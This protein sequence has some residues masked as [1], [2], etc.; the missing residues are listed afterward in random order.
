M[1]RFRVLPVGQAQHQRHHGHAPDPRAR[2]HD[3]RGG[4]PLGVA[5]QEHDADV[6]VDEVGDPAGQEGQGHR[7]HAA[8]V[9]QVQPVL[10]VRG[11]ISTLH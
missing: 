4:A 6:H 1:C 9:P 11:R 7:H 8:G 10:L 3:V 2:Q 5:D